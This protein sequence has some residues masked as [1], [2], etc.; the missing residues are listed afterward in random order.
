MIRFLQQD[1]KL[2]KIL[3][4]VI[5]GAACISMVIYLVP[6]LMDNAGAAD[7]TVFATVHPPG[8]AGRLFGE[9]T[10]IKTDEVTRLAQQ[11]LQ[12]QRLPDFLLSCSSRR[13]RCICRSRT[14]TCGAS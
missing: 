12:Q 9:S 2:T 5:I 7:A 14:T 6:G 4:G 13:T 8:L 11:Q 1:N 3:F 10:Q